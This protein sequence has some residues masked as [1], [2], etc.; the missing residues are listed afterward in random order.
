[1]TFFEYQITIAKIDSTNSYQALRRLHKKLVDDTSPVNFYSIHAINKV[2]KKFKSLTTSQAVRSKDYP[3]GTHTTDFNYAIQSAESKQQILLLL[4]DFQGTQS[5]ELPKQSQSLIHMAN[6][7]FTGNEPEF[8]QI[9]IKS[10]YYSVGNDSDKQISETNRLPMSII[11]YLKSI[12]STELYQTLL[13]DSLIKAK[14]WNG[15]KLPNL[16]E[17][18][19][20][21][22]DKQTN[23]IAAL[24]AAKLLYQELDNDTSG[25][26]PTT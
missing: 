24:K 17:Q 23:Q 1:M 8:K 20:Y 10:S 22:I 7:G 4:A 3:E 6:L 15:T 2:I 25:N 12:E 16:I 14:H 13:S 26:L 21:Q 5:I 19:D 11:C 9:H 18:I